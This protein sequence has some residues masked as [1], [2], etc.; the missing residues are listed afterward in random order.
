MDTLINA[1]ISH[2]SLK[3][4]FENSTA[5][6]ELLKIADA[7]LK[8]ALGILRKIEYSNNKREAINRVLGHLESSHELYLAGWSSYLTEVNIANATNKGLGL[9]NFHQM[10]YK[11]YFVSCFMSLTHKYLDDHVNLIEEKLMFAEDAITIKSVWNKKAK[12]LDFIKKINILL[13]LPLF[14]T[15]HSAKAITLGIQSVYSIEKDSASDVQKFVHDK[16]KY[17]NNIAVMR[18]RLIG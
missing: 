3:L 6:K 14:L 10:R 4:F 1:C 8:A 16:E 13:G 18:S 17:L 5:Y 12:D 7:E 2:S 9:F 11:D 15:A